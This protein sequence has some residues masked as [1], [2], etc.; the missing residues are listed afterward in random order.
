MINSYDFNVMSKIF[1]L[2]LLHIDN[3]CLHD[4]IFSYFDVKLTYFI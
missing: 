1:N 3:I 4:K 2:Y